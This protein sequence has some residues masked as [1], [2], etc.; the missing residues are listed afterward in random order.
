VDSIAQGRPRPTAGKTRANTTPTLSAAQAR[1]VWLRAQRLD[2]RAP[3]GDGV[4]ATRAAVR[5]L[6]YVQIDTI[7]V[8]ERCHHHILYTRI[9]GYRRADLAGAQS[10]DKSVFEYWTHALAYVPTD[11]Y[12]YFIP[13]MQRRRE[14]PPTWF[15]T[16]D[17]VDYRRLLRRIRD[18]GPL[19]IRDIDDDVLVEKDHPW[20]SRK[21]SKRAL[22]LAFYVGDLTISARTGMVKTYELTDRHFGWS[23]RPRAATAGQYAAYLLERAL[24]SQGIVSLDSIC[25]GEANRRKAVTALL[26]AAVRRKQLIPVRVG[27]TD[28]PPHWVAPEAL[29]ADAG[30]E[31]ELV[32]ILSPFDPLIIQRK[33]LS[34]FFGYDHI[35]EA[36][37]PPEKRVLGYFALPVLVGDRIVAAI[38]LKA[39]RTARKLLIQRWTWI[40]SRR[41]GLKRL[42]EDELGRFAAFQFA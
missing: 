18:E 23:R 14:K 40:A 9:P 39:D 17:P 28:S 34:L 35:F 24:R 38:D 29:G 16:V 2:T 10:V 19:T 33:R 32:H 5:H 8:I 3:F 13:A 22:Q 26:E 25:Y 31:A 27:S 21:P 4:A 11:D 42:I 1:A 20:A 6:G 12:R 36:Y 37:V 30:A 7:N 41:T 15:G